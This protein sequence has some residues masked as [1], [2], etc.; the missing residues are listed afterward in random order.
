MR[1]RHLLLTCLTLTA[2]G[3][4]ELTVI[5]H[6]GADMNATD[7]GAHEHLQEDMAAAAQ[8]MSDAAALD[9]GAP[10][11]EEDMGVVTAPEDMSAAPAP[12]MAPPEPDMREEE[13]PPP[14]P[15]K[16]CI[17]RATDHG[18]PMRELDIMPGDPTRLSFEVI[19]V[20]DPSRIERAEL[21][22]ASYDADHPGQEGQIFV[23]GQGGFQ[24]PANAG[25]DN[26][27]GTG[28][29]D[30]TGALVAGVNVIEFGAGTTPRTFY[31]IGDVAIEATAQVE[32]CETPPEPPPAMATERVIDYRG[33]TYTKRH[34]W[35]LRCDGIP[36][37]FTASNYN[38]H[39]NKDCDGAFNPDGSRTGKAIFTFDDVIEATYE[40]QINARHTGNRSSIGALFIVN[41]EEKRL[42]QRTSDGSSQAITTTW[43]QRRLSGTVT[44]TLDSSR[45]GNSDSVQWVKLVPVGP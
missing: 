38:E 14:P 17:W 8:D 16:E 22:F 24:I 44:V 41:G 25:W 26:M 2:L 36:Y 1:P 34:N 21:T 39:H 18:S 43:G 30:I 33:A 4:G 12:D 35:V 13:P 20:P 28:R 37:A 11:P 29:V 40:V 9:M 19:G 31:R 3:C 27:T 23:N 5:D 6:D 15:S 45:E 7:Q 10:A 42:S 32:Q